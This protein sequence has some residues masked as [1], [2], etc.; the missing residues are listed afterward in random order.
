MPY[1]LKRFKNAAPSILLSQFLKALK[2]TTSRRLK[3]DRERFWQERY[4][5]RSVRGEV[6]RL[7]VVYRHPARRS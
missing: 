2:Q 1:G 7:E 4:F 5:D 3:G 6:A